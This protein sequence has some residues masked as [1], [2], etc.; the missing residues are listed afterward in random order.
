MSRSTH[1]LRDPP[2][3]AR[4]ADLFGMAWSGLCAVHCLAM[5]LAFVLAPSLLIALHSHRHPDHALA[6]VLVT[7]TRW[8]WLIASSAVVVALVASVYGLRR[9]RA[10]APLAVTL[11]GAGSLAIALLVPS[12]THHAI[13]HSVL[14]VAGGGCLVAAHAVNLRAHAASRRAQRGF[15]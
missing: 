12:V 1:A 11:A 14:G 4:W 5:P 9:H 8:E 2:F 13:W 6:L 10:Y 3:S 7:M 15:S